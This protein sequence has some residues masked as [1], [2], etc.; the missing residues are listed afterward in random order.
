VNRGCFPANRLYAAH[1]IGIARELR[2]RGRE[3]LNVAHAWMA[4]ADEPEEK[5]G[6]LQW[7]EC[8]HE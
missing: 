2:D 7:Q 6:D 3:M 8:Q 1:C 5:T 4:L